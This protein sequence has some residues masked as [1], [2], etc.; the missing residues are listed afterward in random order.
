VAGSQ[1]TG[2]EAPIA[3]YDHVANFAAGAATIAL[4]LWMAMR[5]QA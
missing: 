4:L 5:L 1:T 3:W 2:A